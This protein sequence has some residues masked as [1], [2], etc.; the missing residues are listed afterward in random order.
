MVRCAMFVMAVALAPA[1]ARADMPPS[2]KRV[3]TTIR[4]DGELPDGKALVLFNTREGGDP[5]PLG[6]AVAF[7]ASRHGRSEM[8]LF[9][10]DAAEI[11]RVDELRFASDVDS[12]RSIIG[13]GAACGS[14]FDNRETV[15]PGSPAVERRYNFAVTF[16][17]GDCVA[18]ML[19]VEL[20]A[21]AKQGIGPD[22]DATI[23]PAPPPL[24][25]PPPPAAEEPA[26]ASAPTGQ[27]RGLCR[28]GDPA[29]PLALLGLVSLAR[30]RARRA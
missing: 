15:A 27:A 8:E 6:I 20:I 4:V 5:I 9:V 14:R 19:S 17:D 28:V 3:E 1:A 23:V 26:E 13:R 16:A 21:A 12:I 7:S 10:V 29:P 25:T 30:R 24:P 18:R 2:G 22:P 11:P